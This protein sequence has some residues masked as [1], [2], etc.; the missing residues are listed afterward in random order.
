MDNFK[1]IVK[2]LTEGRLKMKISHEIPKQL[3]PMHDLISD[4]PYVLGHLLSKDKEYAA[5]YFQKLQTAEFSI[6]DNSAFELGASIDHKELYELA[7]Q[8]KPKV[9]VLPDTLH[10]FLVTVNDSREFYKKYGEELSKNRISCMGVLQGNTL[11]ELTNC[12]ERYIEMGLNYIALPFDCIKDSNWHTIR[13]QIWK[14]MVSRMHRNDRKIHF[15]FLGLQN[16]S[17]LLCYTAEELKWIGS[18]DSSSPII[19]GWVGNEFNDFGTSAEK[20]KLKL[21]ENLDIKLENHQVQSIVHNV[22]KFKTYVER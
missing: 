18:I 1:R 15:H 19:H 13:V 17:E 20:P 6:L 21:A 22:K 3:F 4:Y 2:D 9:L 14:E 10:N 12:W 11:D 7:L 5:F 16:P 8:Y